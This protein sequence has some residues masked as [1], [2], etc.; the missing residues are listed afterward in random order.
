MSRLIHRFD[1]VSGPRLLVVDGSRIYDLS[2]DVAAELDLLQAIG[3]QAVE[4][5]LQRHGLGSVPYID[6]TPLISPPMRSL[7]LAVA[8]TCNL[9]CAY[10]YA[11]GGQFGGTAKIMP[12]SV[13]RSAVLR[14]LDSAAAGDR[15]NLSF[16]GGEPLVARDLIRSTTE[17]ATA[18][19]RSRKVRINFSI[20]TNGT[21]LRDQ[22]CDFF[23]EYGFAVTV[24]ID[25]TSAAH[26]RLRPFRGGEGSYERIIA[27]VSPLLR[28]QQKMQV[29]ARVTVTPLNLGLRKILEE[30]IGLGF[31]S[32]GFSPLLASPSGQFEMQVPHLNRMLAEMIDCGHQFEAEVLAG[33]HYPFSNI[34]EA[35]EQ[36]HRGTH[37]PYPCGA[38]A[39]YFGLSAEGG[40]FAC[41]RFVENPK[42]AFG[43]IERGV[44]TRV[45]Q[46]WL[47]ARHV[48]KQEPC[49]SC[50]AR[51]L[52]GGGCH[53]E[54][55][56]RGRPACDFIRG[57]L[58]YC[59]TVYGNLVEHRPDYFSAERS[60]AWPM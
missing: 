16:L 6:D 28:R 56:H 27:R 45:Q 37:R 18:E 20:T 5:A 13:A 12:W 44:D 36:L 3:D 38:G 22:D 26:D 48:H 43:D 32:V 23:E 24:S 53:H 19:A 33:G 46:A 15:I 55:I 41:H 29:S 11:Q 54:V 42:A 1:S 2:P 4:E 50:W 47:A 10:C 25:G 40:L 35:L 21:L 34:V 8:Q 58:H 9:A 17:F 39:G 14:L 59:L 52:C 57:W 7:S 30:L 49:R 51:Y 60:S 31:H